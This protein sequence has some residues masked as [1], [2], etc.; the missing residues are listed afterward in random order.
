[1]ATLEPGPEDDAPNW[2]AAC[3]LVQS[4]IRSVNPSVN[5]PMQTLAS[6][7]FVPAGDAF[8]ADPLREDG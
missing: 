8:E 6:G 5:S 3:T 7:E 2:M 4:P 1:M